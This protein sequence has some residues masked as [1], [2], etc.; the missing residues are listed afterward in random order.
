MTLKPA[1]TL[2]AHE[3]N[4]K[5]SDHLIESA[6]KVR[7]KA[8]CFTMKLMYGARIAMPQICAIVAK[9]ARQ[10]T[11]LSADSDWRLLRL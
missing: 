11:A 4:S 10:I 2:F 5:D 7:C 9:F 6:G 3:I 1:S 8:A